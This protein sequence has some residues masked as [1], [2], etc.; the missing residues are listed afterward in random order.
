MITALN[1]TPPKQGGR[2]EILM[3]ND[4][5]YTTIDAYIA[6]FPNELRERMELLRKT[7]REAAPNAD[8]I[9]S[10][11]M[12]TFYLN[13]NLVHFAGHKSHIGF[14]PGA[15]GI[16]LFR[17]SFEEGHYSYSKGAV[18]FPHTRPLPVALIREIVLFRVSQNEALFPKKQVKKETNA[19]EGK[20]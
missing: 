15:D 5:E 2:K 17:N 16:E 14:Y 6:R 11:A 19:P 9:I 12:P 18:Q 8:E 4:T 20:K 1:T 7:I 13:G 10:W 3:A